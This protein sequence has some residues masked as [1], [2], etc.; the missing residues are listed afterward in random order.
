MSMGNVGMGVL[1]G[2][3]TM[4]ARR[5]TRRAMHHADGAPK[6]P[7]STRRKRGLGAVLLWAAAAGVILALADVLMEQ[8]KYTE[9]EA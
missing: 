5:A 7:L 4:L 6:L 8:R 2:A 3:T 9:S 1:G